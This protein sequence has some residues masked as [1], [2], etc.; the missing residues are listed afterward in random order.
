[1]TLRIVGKTRLS[2]HPVLVIPFIGK[3][4]LKRF[5]SLLT[6]K[7]FNYNCSRSISEMLTGAE[8]AAEDLEWRVLA[9]TQMSEKSIMA[10]TVINGCMATLSV[11]QRLNNTVGAQGSVFFRVIFPCVSPNV[12]Y[13]FAV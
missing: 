8:A 13:L 4:L 2:S 12:F 10:L 11:L 5:K 6:K 7:I 9:T 3:C 1:M